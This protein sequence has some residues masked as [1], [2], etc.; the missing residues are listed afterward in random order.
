MNE[1]PWDY[2]TL[3][4]HGRSAGSITVSVCSA[5]WHVN[6]FTRGLEKALIAFVSLPLSPQL[7]SFRKARP[8]GLKGPSP[9]EVWVFAKGL[10]FWEGN[11][12]KLSLIHGME[13]R[14]NCW[15][16]EKDFGLRVQ[17]HSFLILLGCDNQP[18]NHTKKSFFW[19]LVL[20]VLILHNRK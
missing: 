3:N 20:S 4:N 7:Q 13:E 5:A 1:A 15:L 6:P 19:C 14:Q 2:C 10:C 17:T 11:K 12:R 18:A 8:Q 9:L 16:S